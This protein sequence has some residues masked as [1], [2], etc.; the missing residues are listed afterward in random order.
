MR[1]MTAHVTHSSTYFI[2]YSFINYINQNSFHYI[3]TNKI[4]IKPVD[5]KQLK[6]D[7]I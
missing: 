3:S 1:N 5:Y 4:Y 6:R 7:A 2:Y